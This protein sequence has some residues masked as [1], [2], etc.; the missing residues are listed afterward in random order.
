MTSQSHTELQNAPIVWPRKADIPAY[1]PA[2][3]VLIQPFFGESM[4]TCWITV[5][6]GA[7]VPPHAHVHEQ[8]GVVIE[9]STTLIANGETRLVGPG[10]G[11]LVPSNVE[12]SGVAGPDGAV[13]VETFVP[14]REDY[15]RAWE[16]MALAE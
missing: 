2:P 13:L 4:M 6:P 15:R 7:T 16:A 9:G 5:E 12:H 1:S 14:I 10:E 8:S 3:G 11:Y